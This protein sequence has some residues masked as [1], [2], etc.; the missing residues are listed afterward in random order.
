[1]SIGLMKLY[2]MEAL[3]QSGVMMQ[4]IHVTGTITEND[5]HQQ[6]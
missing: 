2:P 4:P 5:I 3:Q 6:L 1:M